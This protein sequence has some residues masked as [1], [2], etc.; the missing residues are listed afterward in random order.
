MC[1]KVLNIRQVGVQI[2]SMLTNNIVLS[3]K[4]ASVALSCI[5]D[6]SRTSYFVF[7]RGL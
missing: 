3:S 4:S 5:V 6:T 2:S 1:A 7:I